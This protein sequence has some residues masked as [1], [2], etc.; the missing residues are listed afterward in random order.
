MEEE[1]RRGGAVAAG[2]LPESTT[3]K[4][5]NSITKEFTE[6]N[7]GLGTEKMLQEEKE[8]GPPMRTR[9][10]ATAVHNFGSVFHFGFLQRALSPSAIFPR[11]KPPSFFF[12]WLKMKVQGFVLTPFLYA[13]IFFC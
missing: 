7:P 5:V 4:Q 1:R 8:G 11:L 3:L 9:H 10:L 6:E 13:F 2:S 12:N